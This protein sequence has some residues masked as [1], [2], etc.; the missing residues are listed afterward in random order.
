MGTKDIQQNQCITNVYERYV[1]YENGYGCYATK[2]EVPGFIKK[3]GN[4]HG[5][6]LSPMIND[7]EAAD[8]KICAK[9][10]L[11]TPS[12]IGFV[13]SEV[14]NPTLGCFLKS[15]SYKIAQ[16]LNNF[17]TYDRYAYSDSTCEVGS[18]IVT[19]PPTSL[20]NFNYQSC[21]SACESDP[22]CKHFSIGAGEC[23]SYNT[24]Q[25]DK[26][27]IN[28]VVCSHS[29]SIIPKETIYD[30][31]VIDIVNDLNNST[32]VDLQF[33]PLAIRYPFPGVNKPLAPILLEV[34]GENLSCSSGQLSNVMVYIPSFPQYK[35]NFEGIFQIC[36]LIFFNNQQCKYSCSCDNRFC[37]GLYIRAFSDKS[38]S[39]ICEVK[40]P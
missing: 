26:E 23:F 19:P 31:S 30:P 21:K 33:N 28:K 7:P 10:C 20:G 9:Y 11:E 15:T 13:V 18:C 6:D 34:I 12:C 24:C 27:N 29:K 3:L 35:V 1:C 25:N 38:I 40:F 14:V 36:K 2:Y 16:S 8:P 22:L 5:F 4:Y 37:E 17:L 32:C 39:K